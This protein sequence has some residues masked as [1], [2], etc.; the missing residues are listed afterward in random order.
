MKKIIIFPIILL[1][2]FSTIQPALAA[3]RSGETNT[4]ITRIAPTTV[5][6]KS[7]STHENTAVK[8][9]INIP[10]YWT[11]GQAPV[12]IKKIYDNTVINNCISDSK[13]DLGIVDTKLASIDYND[14]GEIVY[15][16][17]VTIKN[18]FDPIMVKSIWLNVYD[19][20]QMSKGGDIN[21]YK[22]IDEQKALSTTHV[23]N[24]DNYLKLGCDETYIVKNVAIAMKTTK[25]KE[26]LVFVLDNFNVLSEKNESGDLF[27]IMSN[28]IYQYNMEHPFASFD[29]NNINLIGN[30][31]SF[32]TNLNTLGAKNLDEIDTS[33]NQLY[34]SIVNNFN[35]QMVDGQTYEDSASGYKFT[36]GFIK[37]GSPA[38]T[39]DQIVN[40]YALEKVGKN[41][42]KTGIVVDTGNKQPM[43]LLTLYSSTLD[44][45]IPLFGHIYLQSEAGNTPVICSL[46]NP[47]CLPQNYLMIKSLGPTEITIDPKETVGVEKKISEFE[48]CKYGPSTAIM[49]AVKI[50]EEFESGAKPSFTRYFRLDNE[51]IWEPLFFSGDWSSSDTSATVKISQSHDITLKDA[52]LIST[53]DCV[54]LQTGI[55]D[56]NGLYFWSTSI[57]G[58]KSSV[59]AYVFNDITDKYY[60]IGSE[61]TTVF[62]EPV[63][64][65]YRVVGTSAIFQPGTGY[66]LTFENKN[67]EAIGGSNNIESLII[68]AETKQSNNAD[69]ESLKL[70][71]T[72]TFDNDPE[73][74]QGHLSIG[75]ANPWHNGKMPDLWPDYADEN[76]DVTIVPITIST[77]GELILPIDK[78]LGY[79]EHIIIKLFI[80]IPDGI[81]GDLNFSLSE[82]NPNYA[83]NKYIGDFVSIYPSIFPSYNLNLVTTLPINRK[84]I[85]ASSDS[86]NTNA[87]L[88][89]NIFDQG[90]YSKWVS[91][92]NYK[93]PDDRLFEIYTNAIFSNTVA[94]I[95]L[96]PI[97]AKVIGSFS[98]PVT[99]RIEKRHV[100][101]GEPEIEIVNVLP[102]DI[103]TL[104]DSEYFDIAGDS[105]AWYKVY[106]ENYPTGSA[107]DFI[108]FMVNPIETT[109]PDNIPALVN[110]KKA[111]YSSV[112][113]EEVP[114][115]D[116]IKTADMFFGAEALY[117]TSNYNSPIPKYLSISSTKDQAVIM[118]KTCF[119]AQGD[120]DIRSITYMHDE[121][122]DQPFDKVLLTMWDVTYYLPLDA[123]TTFTATFDTDSKGTFSI[124]N[125]S[126]VCMEM[127]VQKPKIQLDDTFFNLINIDAKISGTNISIPVL[128]QT[129]DGLSETQPVKGTVTNFY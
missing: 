26:D 126:E 20:T 90:G 85:V 35:D 61:N 109:N 101:D 28:N 73:S 60:K 11:Y 7:Q 125:G 102:G 115:V 64:N 71:V 46:E 113:L 122:D 110:I 24:T 18:S 22:D 77:N 76:P 70:N 44:A 120:L 17:D 47:V 124:N 88:L 21:N 79:G 40:S 112:W 52:P 111:D 92:S 63:V 107:S 19:K 34:I 38:L 121:H 84:I 83:N 16:F 55:S 129:G 37:S 1:M 25:E 116:P 15:I 9:R 58:I 106:F 57:E 49:E 27:A 94:S 51:L 82:T 41:W 96:A 81:N 2:V 114:F 32:D 99:L 108:S 45:Y 29:L 89:V 128:L 33:S 3:S 75:P 91:I 68:K 12:Q 13:P 104:S 5:E 123:W 8:P 69:L 103:I 39:A 97:T 74:L 86:I 78:H 100:Y 6:T 66:N 53:G 30:E 127:K 119:T 56:E 36:K 93:K 50:K 59:P 98:K 87:K 23:Y 95:K 14:S 67:V 4:P 10:T 118:N 42:S 48:I 117:Q 72:N 65:P 105:F 43:I 80:D 62:Y 31:L 54:T